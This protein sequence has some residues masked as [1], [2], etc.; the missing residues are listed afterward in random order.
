MLERELYDGITELSCHPGYSRDDFQ[1]PYDQE[2][3]VE[4]CTLS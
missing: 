2:R 1:S 3:E 4:P